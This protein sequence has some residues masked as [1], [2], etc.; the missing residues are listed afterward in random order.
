MNVKS[1]YGSLVICT[2]LCCIFEKRPVWHP[3]K[4]ME[5]SS[6]RVSPLKTGQQM[7]TLERAAL[8][9]L[10]KK[11]A[12][13]HLGTL[14]ALSNAGASLA[15]KKVWPALVCRF[16]TLCKWQMFVKFFFKINWFSGGWQLAHHR[17]RNF[18][19]SCKVSK[20][21]INGE[22]R[23][24]AMVKSSL[25]ELQKAGHLREVSVEGKSSHLHAL[26]LNNGVSVSLQHLFLIF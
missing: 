3:K 6:F 14:K 23:D 15:M 5:E 4:V 1:P 10:S 2:M 26:L 24:R 20:V 19:C 16:T 18:V 21:L 8:A 9:A 7:N 25:E 17:I 11:A 12:T 13:G 22:K